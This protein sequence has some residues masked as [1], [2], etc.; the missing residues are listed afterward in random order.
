MK[1]TVAAV[2]ATITLGLALGASAQVPT[3]RIVTVDLN[4]IFNEYYKT[5]IASS[6]LKETADSFNK[7]HEEMLANYK[8]EIDD[9]NKLREEQDKPEYSADVRQQKKKALED[10]LV[11]TNKIQHDIDASLLKQ[12]AYM[13]HAGRHGILCERIQNNLSAVR[14]HGGFSQHSFGVIHMQR[15]PMQLPGSDVPPSRDGSAEKKLRHQVAPNESL[16]ARRNQKVLFG[17]G[18]GVGQADERSHQFSSSA[19]RP[20]GSQHFRIFPRRIGSLHA[21]EIVASHEER[22]GVKHLGARRRVVHVV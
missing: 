21:D 11:E 6:K 7:E 4:R 18:Q 10:K 15:H 3:G 16:L 13:R 12:L 22:I 14:V 2:V 19:G 9:V 1:N 20:P 8:K 5:P 17:V